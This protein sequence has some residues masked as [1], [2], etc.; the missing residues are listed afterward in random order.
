MRLPQGSQSMRSSDCGSSSPRIDSCRSGFELMNG[1][2][3]LAQVATELAAE[4]RE[5]LD[6]E[7]GL[8]HL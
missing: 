5:N 2:V 6:R 8:P 7:V 4:C 1:P 3:G